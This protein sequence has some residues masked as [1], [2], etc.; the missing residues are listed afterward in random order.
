MRFLTLL[1]LLGTAP[2]FA[3]PGHDVKGADWLSSLSHRLLGFDVVV[4]M[5]VAAWLVLLAV[6]A[7][8]IK[9]RLTKPLQRALHQKAKT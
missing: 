8:S 7:Y 6:A 3:H 1:L 9:R 4:L 2:A 5:L